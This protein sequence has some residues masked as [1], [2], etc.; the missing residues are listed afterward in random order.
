MKLRCNISNISSISNNVTLVTEMQTPLLVPLEEAA[1]KEET[2]RDAMAARATPESG[3]TPV[4]GKT[5]RLI[6]L[7][8]AVCVAPL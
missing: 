1:E 7:R 6:A 5:I 2:G 3:S 4:E 8:L